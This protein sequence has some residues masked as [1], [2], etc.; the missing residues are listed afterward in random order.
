M[1]GGFGGGGGLEGGGN[2][3]YTKMLL[4]NNLT[5]KVQ[6]FQSFWL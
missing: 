1:G 4:K 5:F 3:P 2:I 6:S